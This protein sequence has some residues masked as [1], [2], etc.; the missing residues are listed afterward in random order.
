M[1]VPRPLSGKYKYPESRDAWKSKNG[2]IRVG[3]YVPF[4]WIDW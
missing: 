1:S 3:W 2:P 4:P